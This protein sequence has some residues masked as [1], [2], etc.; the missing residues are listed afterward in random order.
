M[1]FAVFLLAC[2]AAKAQRT[3]FSIRVTVE[4]SL[5]GQYLENAT[6][7]LLLVPEGTTVYQRRIE[8]RDLVFSN[9]SSGTYRLITSFLGYA[10]DTLPITFSAQ[11]AGQITPDSDRVKNVRVLLHHSAKNLV[12]VI[13]NAEIPPG[14]VKNDTLAFNAAAFPT[15]SNSTVEDLLR[16]LPG[17]DIDKDG[18]ITMQGQKIDKIYLDGKEF[19]LNDPRIATQNLPSDLVDQI[20]VFDSQT[21]RARLTG[22][23]EVTGTKSLNIRLKKNRKTG[24][25]ENLY[26]GAGTAAGQAGR[27]GNVGG[28]NTTGNPSVPAGDAY[29]SG[30]TVTSLGKSW[31]FAVANLNNVNNQFTGTDNR[32][33]PGTG[34]IQTFKSAYAN[35]R[36]DKSSKLAVTA[37]AGT[38]GVKTS[39]IQTTQQQTFLTD[40]SL[41]QQA[42]GST[43]SRTQSYFGNVFLEYNIDTLSLVNLRSAWTMQNAASSSQDTVGISTEKGFTGYVSNLGSTDNSNRSS[44]SSLANTF[45]FRRRW[46]RPGQ[47]LVISLMQ[48]G[49]HQYQ[50]QNIYNLVDNF[51]SSGNLDSRT[52]TNQSLTILSKSNSY[53]GFLS[54]TEPLKPGCRLEFNYL[55]N[56]SASHSDQQSYD[57][58]SATAKFDLPDSLTTDHFF[59]DNTIQRFSSSYNVMEGKYHYQLG[60]T[61]QV[62]SLNDHNLT[63]GGSISQ[64]QINWYPRAFLIYTPEIGK[65]LNLAYSVTTTSPTVQQLQPVPDL[66]NPSLVKVGNPGLLQQLTH[67]LTGFYTVFNSEDFQNLQV[68]LQGNYAQHEFVPATT[69]L[70]GGIQQI[71]YVNLDGVWNANAGATYGFPIG[72]QHKANSSVS[73]H[74]QYNHNLSLTNG[75]EV[76]TT[77]IGWGS[78]WKLNYHPIEKLFLESTAALTYTGAFYS[79]DASQNAQTWLQNYSVE[80]SYELPGFITLT[81]HLNAQ[82]TGRQAGLPART[83]NLWNAS[84]FKDFLHDR[85]GQIRLSAFGILNTPSNYTQSVGINYLQTQQSNLPGR[86][87]LLSFIYHFKSKGSGK[88]P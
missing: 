58:D 12:Q 51:D 45:S 3:G 72:N 32:N 55:I 59:T 17:I 41:L 8:K 4:D 85:R 70:S 43:Q 74:F 1:I 83:V 71:Q 15:R 44:G 26:A 87:L 84:I 47:T 75:A 5:N 67:T 63:T 49:Q 35:F 80:V 20:E 9:L 61:L 65:N 42:Y 78:S 16:K 57:F 82:I 34:G 30:G 25:I 10:T 40:F 81:S 86:I 24:Y 37:N 2:I 28:D 19:Y 73:V 62:S 7:S 22:V 79:I 64:H 48:S 46:S 52:L 29:S 53:G 88:Q 66:T 56:Q 36:N 69:I 68:F 76:V 60:A 39:L 38:S 21:E 13:V 6:V 33:G 23:R 14:A 18:N 27:P 50:P 77:G 11:Q 54:Y 31:G